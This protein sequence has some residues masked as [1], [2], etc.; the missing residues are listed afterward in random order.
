MQ[1]WIFLRHQQKLIAAA[2]TWI[3]LALLLE[4]IF[5]F[6]F[7]FI[8]YCFKVKVVELAMQLEKL[9]VKVE[10]VRR[11]GALE[12]GKQKSLVMVTEQESRTFPKEEKGNETM[13]QGSQVREKLKRQ[14]NRLMKKP[15]SKERVNLEPTTLPE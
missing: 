15:V 3:S 6:L 7:S 11:R 9:Q 12:R 2:I 8:L 4:G 14:E 10:A 13:L 1:G 5:C